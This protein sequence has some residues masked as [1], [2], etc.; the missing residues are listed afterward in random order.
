[1]K[2]TY[3]FSHDYNARSDIKIRKLIAKHGYIGYGIFWGIIEDL[4][5]NAN[6]MPLDYFCL[7]N[8]YKTNEDVINSIINDFGL[9]E[10]DNN[11]FGSLSVQKRLDTRKEKSIKARIS[12]YKRWGIC[13]G[14]ANA[15]QTECA[16]NAIKERKGKENKG[17]E[18]VRKSTVIDIDNKKNNT[19]IREL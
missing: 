7:S 9:F 14:N 1:M 16:P 8:E 4:Y 18:N 17:K 10:V 2:E 15:L 12:A 13:E 19:D 3:Y 6:E 5:N 11:I